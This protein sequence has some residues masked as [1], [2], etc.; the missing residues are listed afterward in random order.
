MAESI[1]EKRYRWCCKAL[2][3]EGLETRV[4]DEC[5]RKAPGFSSVQEFRFR[6]LTCWSKI[7]IPDPK[8]TTLDVEDFARI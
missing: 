4:C 6:C 8:G 2:S 7:R 5:G 1:E 3:S